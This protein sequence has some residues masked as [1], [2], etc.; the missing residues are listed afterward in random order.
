[1]TD[2]PTP[3]TGHLSDQAKTD[4]MTHDEIDAAVAA[5]RREA[6]GRDGEE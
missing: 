2:D 4:T 6:A 3:D 5:H 1:M